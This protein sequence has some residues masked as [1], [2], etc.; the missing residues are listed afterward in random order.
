[1][2]GFSSAYAVSVADLPDIAEVQERILSYADLRAESL[3]DWRSRARKAPLLPRLQLGIDRDLRRNLNQNIDDSVSVT[4]NGVVVGPSSQQNLLQNNNQL[5]F[6]VKAIWSLDQLLSSQEDLAIS[7]EARY[8]N[9]E[10]QRLL[11]ETTQNYFDLK[12][13]LLRPSASSDNQLLVEEKI[14]LLNGATGGWFME[15]LRGDKG[16]AVPRVST[17]KRKIQSGRALPQRRFSDNENRVA[18]TGDA[19]NKSELLSTT[20][21]QDTK[22]QTQPENQIAAEKEETPRAA[23]DSQMPPLQTGAPEASP[24][25]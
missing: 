10:R 24:S 3:Q 17:Q 15:R 14:A 4:G 9:Q 16:D 19:A 11:Q 18:A 5:T 20:S 13:L 1:M 12:Q 22:F 7:Q 6:S 8:L 2:F 25:R 23:T 21:T